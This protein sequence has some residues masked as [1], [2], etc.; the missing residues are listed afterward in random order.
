MALGSAFCGWPIFAAHPDQ[1]V[2]QKGEDWSWDLAQMGGGLS[3]GFSMFVQYTILEWGWQIAFLVLASVVIC[4]LLPLFLVLLY[5]RPEEKGLSAY[6]GVGIGRRNRRPPQPRSRN[7][8]PDERT[9]GDLLRTC[10]LM[11]PGAGSLPLLGHRD[12]PRH[13]PSG[14]IFE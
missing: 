6:G 1:L 9:L 12:L 5:Y 3:F 11:D 10:R 13:G 4:S 14:E 7:L 2:W 8:F